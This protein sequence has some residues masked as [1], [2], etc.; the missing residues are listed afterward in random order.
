M[1]WWDSYEIAILWDCHSMK[2]ILMRLA[3]FHSIQDQHEGKLISEEAIV[4]ELSNDLL[5]QGYALFLDS[6]YSTANLYNRL[7]HNNTYAVRT[8][9][10]NWISMAKSFVSQHLSMG[11]CA[12]RMA[13][14]I[15]CVK[16]QDKK[17]SLVITTKYLKPKMVDTRTVWR[18]K[19][20]MKFRGFQ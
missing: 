20:G 5:N 18:K 2:W 12:F 11:Q 17:Q 9:K 14:H 4:L 10:S 19:R 3:V 15:L 16:W 8:V 13:N 6:W 1:Y 7:L